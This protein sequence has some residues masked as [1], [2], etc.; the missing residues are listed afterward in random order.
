[1]RLTGYY[2]ES[3]RDPACGAVAPGDQAGY[4]SVSPIVQG[5]C[6]AWEQLNQ[7]KISITYKTLDFYPAYEKT[8][9]RQAYLGN[10]IHTA[11]YPL[12]TDNTN[13]LFCMVVFHFHFVANKVC[14]LEHV[15]L[16]LSHLY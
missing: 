3:R 10:L 11:S 13:M 16:K 8:I 4:P 14:D 1:V 12:V 2:K 15:L 9:R 7:A 5:T 6:S